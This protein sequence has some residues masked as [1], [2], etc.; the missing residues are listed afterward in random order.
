MRVLVD[1]SVW[2]LT[3]RRRQSSPPEAAE[4]RRLVQ[5]GQVEIIG[6]IR[7]ELLSG[8]AQ[9]KQF[10]ALRGQLES[11]EDIPLARRH[12]EL[13]AEF[14]N[15]C[16]RQGIQG[17][18]TDFLICAVASLEHLAIFTTDKDFT[19]YAKHLPLTLHRPP[20]P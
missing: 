12:F 6:P 17:S 4:L 15:R 11:F 8:L 1:T 5:Q 20:A 13:A 7:Q 3:L 10:E 9:T 14:H 2:S 19:H 16:R 18:H